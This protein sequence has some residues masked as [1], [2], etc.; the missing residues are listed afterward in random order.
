MLAASSSLRAAAAG[1][2]SG[3]LL[4]LVFPRTEAGTLAWVALVPLLH[5]VAGGSARERLLAGL[6]FGLVFHWGNVYWVSEVMVRYGGLNRPLS[7]LILLIL[8]AY[9]TLFDCLLAVFTGAACARVGKRGLFFAPLLWVGL[10]FWRQ[11]PW[12]GFPWCFIGYSQASFLP[13][14]QI[15]SITG[16][17]GVSFLI[18]LVNALLA[19]ALGEQG[20]GK[21]RRVLLAAAPVGLLLLL[22]LGFGRAE[23]ARPL[24]AADF[25]VAAVQGAVLQEH[26]WDPGYA[27]EIFTRHMTL[28]EEAAASG[29]EL[30][31]WPES[32]TPFH[33]DGSPALAEAM[34]DFARQRRIY[35]LFGS[36]DYEFETGEP[37]PGAPRAYRAYNGA[38]LI[39]PR[40]EIP[41]RYHKI[42]LVPF[43][44][45]VPMRRILFFV[46]NLTQEV[47]GFTPGTRIAVGSLGDGRRVGVFICYE[48]IY[49][50]LVRRFTSEG[51]GLLV[52]LTNDAWFGKSAAPYQHFVMATVRAI[53]NRRYL[54]RAA[55]TGISAIVDP[56][57]RVLAETELFR[58][59]V[60]TGK[61]SFRSDLTFYARHGDLLARTAAAVTL[62]FAL[63]LGFRFLRARSRR[64]ERSGRR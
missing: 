54:V 31:V 20:P 25:A 60:L 16:I 64:V 13:A 11:F 43:G 24:P 10:E 55:N 50:D 14:L 5:L 28:S 23:L 3:A 47:G 22:A 49:P 29:S 44:E 45:Y 30:V 38:K 1:A 59:E 21:T 35:L 18:V 36:D 52:Q 27:A 63:L 26:K 53:E 40:G 42:V 8:I 2:L 46:G 33:F 37:A 9:L 58:A 61:V 19:Y 6:A 7:L 57:G 32:S 34:K 41:F 56:Y 4:I 12:G 48:A 17:Y 51:A 15:A 62:L 39:D